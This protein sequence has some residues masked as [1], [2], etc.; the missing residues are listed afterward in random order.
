MLLKNDPV[1]AF[2]DYEAVEVPS[3]A[4]GP[5]KGLTFAVKDIYDVAGYPT[6]GGSPI[7]RAES[8][9]HTETAPI[10]AAMLDAGAR[11]VGKTQ[12]DELTFSMNGQ[13]KHFPEPVN[14]ARRGAHHRRLVL[15][16][17]GGG[18]R[19]PLR[20]RHRLRYG[21]LGAR[22]GEL[23]RALGHPPDAWARAARPRHAARAL[24]RHGRLFR[25]RCRRSSRKVAPV[26]LGEDERPFALTPARARRRCLR[27]A[28]VRARGG[29]A[30][31]GGGEGRGGARR[32]PSASPSRRRGWSDWYWTFRRLQAV[33]AWKAHGAWI[34]D[35]DPGHDA[36]RARALRVRQRRSTPDER[37][38][39]EENRDA[40][41]RPRRGDR[42]RRRRADAA[43][44]AG[45]RAEARS[46][47]RRAAGLSRAGA[48][49]PL[50]RRAFR[51]AAGHAC[52]S[53]RSTAAPLGLSLIGPRGAD[54]ALVAL[55]IRIAAA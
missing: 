33:E 35:R 26:F 55:A 29:G 41:A 1:N 53:P 5:L 7:K 20:L 10:V 11:F 37:R 36:G 17:G 44:R 40:P 19:R 51:P 43:D 32:R 31:P 38:T 46:L 24:L 6:G 22:A 14:V 18:R 30:A 8:P 49:H 15:R 47:R 52:R 45:D 28:H 25:R 2:L 12:T 42:R 48:L 13:N 4:T 21:R 54:R 16:L 27:A 23:L 50:H 9:I 34:E 3:A 39:A